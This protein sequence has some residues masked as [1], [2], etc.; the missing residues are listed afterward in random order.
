MA[1]VGLRYDELDNHAAKEAALKAFIAFYIHQYQLKSLEIMGAKASNKVMGT[2]NHVLKENAYHG[3]E[4]LAEISERLCKSAYEE[5]LSELTDV[6][7]DQEGGPIVP[8]EKMW[9]NEEENLPTED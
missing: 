6:K 7:F 4:E 3:E 5:V 1:Q 9:Q 2:I 8:L